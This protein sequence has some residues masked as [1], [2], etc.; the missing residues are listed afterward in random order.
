MR[1]QVNY[2]QSLSPHI[3][4]SHSNEPIEEEE[5]EQEEEEKVKE[6]EEEEEEEEKEEEEDES[7]PVLTVPLTCCFL[8][9]GDIS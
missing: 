6:E 2:L 4:Q 3:H 5:E 7:S 9:S 1:T 8:G